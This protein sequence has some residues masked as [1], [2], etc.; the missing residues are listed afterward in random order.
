MTKK[1]KEA[2]LRTAL[3]RTPSSKANTPSTVNPLRSI[4]INRPFPIPASVRATLLKLHE[5]GHVAYL[6]GGC[7]RDFLLHRPVKDHD[8]ATSA[9][10]DELMTLFPE[11]ITVGIQF[12]VLKVPDPERA[13]EMIEVASFR[14][15]LEYRDHRHPVSVRFA[16]I[17]EDARR[18]DFTV[19]ALYFDLKESRVLDC[20]GGV[21][22][23]KAKVIRAIGVPSD[24]FKEDALRLIRAIRFSRAL[25]FEI[26]S[27]TLVAVETRAKL[28]QKISGERVREEMGRIFTGP[29]PSRALQTM[30]KTGLFQACF[31]ELNC[32]I[33]LDPRVDQTEEEIWARTLLTLEKLSPEIRAA[34]PVLGWI[35][36]LQEVG[37]LSQ[38][39]VIPEHW[40][41][42]SAAV[43]S[44]LGERLRF[45]GAD[46]EFMRFCLLDQ[47][48]FRSVF[49]MREATLLRWIREPYFPVLLE[50]HR[51]SAL[52]Q[53]G[54]LTYFEFCKSRWV[55]DQS[56]PKEPKW[57]TGQDLIEMGLKPGPYFSLILREVE[58]LGIEGKIRS[59]EHAIEHALQ[60]ATSFER[61]DA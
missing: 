7:V 29:E 25:G 53:D 40:E 20:V 37:K 38:K 21:D 47:R 34:H 36:L 35:A 50:F 18:R 31:P 1:P 6:V 43:A 11:G 58:D 8:I 5:N 13:G 45:S 10:P 46:L 49:S 9:K 52:A 48:K 28:I 44:V 17:L 41:A 14:E 26:E 54:N 15:D 23:L 55:L 33:S 2:K 61:G 3:K 24:R 12:G 39:P 42:E 51:A 19:N 32:L 59:K 22:D 60:L 4:R 16:G 57:L 30:R 27:K 56:R